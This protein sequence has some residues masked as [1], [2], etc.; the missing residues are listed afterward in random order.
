MFQDLQDNLELM[1]LMVSQ[2]HPV[3]QEPQ[4][5]QELQDHRELLD[6][7]VNQGILVR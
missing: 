5:L 1:E 7:P 4:V 6:S 2:E 3:R